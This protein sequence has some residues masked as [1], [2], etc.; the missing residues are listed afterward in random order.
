MGER[1]L[2]F[3]CW[4]EG[5]HLAM[6]VVGGTPNAIDG[7]RFEILYFF[8]HADADAFVI[9]GIDPARVETRVICSRAITPEGLC[10]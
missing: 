10:I 9:N 6:Q 8:T 1:L 3:T 2:G 4:T 7:Y 5:E